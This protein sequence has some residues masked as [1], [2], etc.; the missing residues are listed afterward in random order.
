L[1]KKY[2]FEFAKEKKKKK[3]KKKKKKPKTFQT[4]P[5]A[6]PLRPNILV[7][8]TPGTG[9]TTLCELIAAE[10]GMTHINCGE[11]VRDRGLH[12]GHLAEV[13]AFDLN[14]DKLLD[15]MEDTMVAGGVVVD[16]HSCDFFPERWF[17]LVIVLRCNNTMLF[18][19][20]K[21]RAYADA[22]I[23]ENIECEIM[24]VVLEEARES[25]KPEIVVEWRSEG[26]EDMDTNAERAAQWFVE[27]D[28]G[29][30]AR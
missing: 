30:G 13:D 15:A 4:E 14:E 26:L 21:A 6:Q 11:W 18:D 3:T 1:Q 22:K 27:H 16:F 9:K 5:M 8:G 2:F 10:T 12:D 17:Q 23:R 25:Y 20:L 28:T 19:R 24:Q 29:A 7:T